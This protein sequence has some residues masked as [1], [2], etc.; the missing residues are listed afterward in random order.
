[1]PPN[2]RSCCCPAPAVYAVVL[3]DGDGHSHAPVLLCRHH[4]RRSLPALARDGVAVFDVAGP[5]Y[6]ARLV[7]A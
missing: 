2:A 7:A 5:L 1:M 4:A 6:D 3:S